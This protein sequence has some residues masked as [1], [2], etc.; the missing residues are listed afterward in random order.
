MYQLGQY[1][2]IFASNNINTLNI[3]SILIFISNILQYLTLTDKPWSLAPGEITSHL[4]THDATAIW[5]KSAPKRAKM[6]VLW[7]IVQCTAGIDMRCHVL[8]SECSPA[9]EL[10]Y[11]VCYLFFK[12]P[13]Y[14]GPS[15]YWPSLKGYRVPSAKKWDL[16]EI[17][18]QK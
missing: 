9:A 10:Q 16:G 15:T 12:T 13:M 3:N 5:P 11:I 18:F 17:A 7:F 6:T 8:C 4:D 1:H 14:D 2:T